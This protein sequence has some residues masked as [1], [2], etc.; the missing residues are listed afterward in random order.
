MAEP[1]DQAAPAPRIKL[2][3]LH[4]EGYR[5]LR[6]VRWPEDGLGWDGAVPDTVLVGGLN[7]SGKTT[8][9]EVI[10]SVIRFMI[11]PSSARST[12][13][14]VRAMLPRCAL[15][16]SVI[17]GTDEHALRINLPTDFRGAGERQY[18][19]NFGPG[20]NALQMT[21]E[22]V[23]DAVRGKLASEFAQPEG[24]R[25]LYF[26]TD[27]A[28]LFPETAF[29]GPGS[30]QRRGESP[31]YR[32][33]PP[34]DWF[35]SVE[36]IL[37]DAKWTDLLAISKGKPDPGHFAAFERVMQ[38]FFAGEKQLYWSD[39]GALHVKM[40]DGALHPLE[41]LSSGEKQVLLFAAELVDRWAPGSLV[42]IDEPE[43]HLHE[44]W[45]AALWQLICELQRERG[46]QVIVTTQSNYLWGLGGLGTHVLLG[47]WKP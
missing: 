27:R 19:V 9:L 43:L 37:Y 41:A 6:C 7:G 15:H 26:P 45:L 12:S 40:K 22:P 14:D 21:P 24:P 36:A 30:R 46:G 25:L 20:V 29:K 31:I 39:D 42:L 10:F 23:L 47:G 33:A 18:A 4:V 2:T 1:P 16:L 17:L 3:R 34:S 8:L 38:R 13:E 28:V 44:A 5:S 35:G 11:A 32:Y